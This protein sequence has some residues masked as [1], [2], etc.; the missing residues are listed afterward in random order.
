MTR[1]SKRRASRRRAKPPQDP[2]TTG[3]EIQE[4]EAH[5]RAGLWP[6][7]IAPILAVLCFAVWS[8]TISYPFHFDD[9]HSIR[10][11]EDIRRIENLSQFLNPRRDFLAK[12]VLNAG[13]TLNY[14][15][16]QK[17]EDGVPSPRAFHAVNVLIHTLNAVLVFLLVFLF[18]RGDR[19][20]IRPVHGAL[21][22]AG[23]AG[24]F[25]MSPIQASA[26][27]LIAS[28]SVMQAATFSLIALICVVLALDR[29]RS[30]TSRTTLAILAV[31]A[32][33]FSLGSKAVGVATAGLAAALAFVSFLRQERETTRWEW[34]GF[35]AAII[36]VGVGA[37]VLANRKGQGWQNAYGG[38]WPYF[39]TQTRVVLRYLRL[40]AYPAGL[41]VDPHVV[42]STSLLEPAAAAALLTVLALVVAGILLAAR[43]HLMGL[44]IL[45]YFVA[46]APSSSI[47]PRKDLMLEYR[48]YLATVGYAGAAVVLLCALGAFLRKRA[49]IRAP[50]GAISGILV[51]LLIA[52]LTAATLVRSR[53]F[54]DEVALWGD[55]AR[56]AP[57]KPRPNN[58][59]ATVLMEAGRVDEAIRQYKY[60]LRIEPRHYRAHYYLGLALAEKGLHEE[61]AEEYRVSLSLKPDNN[62]VKYSLALTLKERGRHADAIKLLRDVVDADPSHRPAHAAL[63]MS[64]TLEGRN[65]EAISEFRTLLRLWPDHHDAPVHH[66]NLGQILGLKGHL[67][68]AESHYR[69]ALRRRPDYAKAHYNLG[70]VLETTNRTQEA[71]DHF[72]TAL[73][74]DSA[75]PRPALLDKE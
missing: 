21:A 61:A 73:S 6:W 66:Y 75:L 44:A 74:L 45:W 15:V 26:I 30:I 13:Y 67:D 62:V 46:L 32:L 2:A 29:K 72:R 17:D 65:E 41:S 48:A 28:R 31:V 12:G 56:K 69:Q 36:A 60:V 20:N 27:N 51:V 18:F 16:A 7:L 42:R 40:L 70:G 8:R 19:P 64:L 5:R 47:I 11:N 39:L 50:V 25:C 10:D 24:V 52:G 53:V 35:A 68:K 3:A 43:R 58:N 71:L 1:K 38:V 22:S 49:K 4:K 57:L 9:R 59:L 63:A 37:L 55:A 34:C 54:A 23:V 33:A 14:A